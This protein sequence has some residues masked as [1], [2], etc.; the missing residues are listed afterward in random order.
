MIHYMHERGHEIGLH[1]ALNGL[2]DMD[3]IRK[4]IMQEIN[5][6]SEMFGFE[7]MEFSIHRPSADVLRRT[8]SCRHHQ[9]LSDEYFTFAEKV[10]PDTKL[11]VKYISDAQHRWNYGKPDRETLLETIRYRS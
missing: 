5:V 10:T 1:F 3:L 4:K 11:A 8:S 2:T 7:I 9:C 6:L